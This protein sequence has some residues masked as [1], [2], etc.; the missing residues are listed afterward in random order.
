MNHEPIKPQLLMSRKMLSPPRP[1]IIVV[2]VLDLGVAQ[3]DLRLEKAGSA[4]SAW[5]IRLFKSRERCCRS[6]IVDSVAALNF[7]FRYDPKDALDL[8][9]S[10]LNAEQQ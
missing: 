3:Q 5:Y 1:W 4:P 9:S 10:M 7:V 6:N 8:P 2:G